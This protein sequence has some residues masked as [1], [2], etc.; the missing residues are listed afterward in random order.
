[1]LLRAAASEFGWKL[2]LADNRLRFN[3]SLF[4]VDVERMQTTIFDTSIANL[5]FSDNAADAEV[6]GLEGDFVWLP[7]STEGLTISGAFSFLDTEITR[8]ITPTNDVTRGDSL[9]FAPEFQATLRAR[10]EWEVGG[11]RAHVMPHLTHSAESY[12]DII[13]INR[14]RVDGWTMLGVTAGVTA[15]NW[16]AEFY[17]DNLTDERAEISRSFVFDRQRVSYARPR[18]IGVRFSYDL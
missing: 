5:F 16:T 13:R 12:S 18:T 10:Y 11:L 8:V 1:M 7:E 15:D 2:N 9:A 14:D 4:F 6:R 3:G 17:I